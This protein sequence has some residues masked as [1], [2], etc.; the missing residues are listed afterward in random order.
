MKKT[1]F[2]ALIA[3]TVSTLVLALGMCMYTLPEWHLQQFGMPMAIVG[4][5]LEIISW[6][7]QRR[8][9]G[10]GA[11]SV[12]IAL[13]GKAFYVIVAALVFGGGFALISSGTFVLGLALSFVGLIL[14][15]GMV[16]VVIGLK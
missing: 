12:N 10:K 5:V 9:A 16:P 15:I 2:I 4:I 6:G 14:L 3:Y 8:L 1:D 13:V 7:L 11:P